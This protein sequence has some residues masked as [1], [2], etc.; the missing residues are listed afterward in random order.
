M[1]WLLNQGTISVGRDLVVHNDSMW[2]DWMTSGM[3]AI[4]ESYI[5][6]QWDTGKASSSVDQIVA[7]LLSLPAAARR[8]IFHSWEARV[9]SLLARLLQYPSSCCGSL[10]GRIHEQADVG[11]ELFAEYMDPSLHAS[12]G[13]WDTETTSLD[14]AQKNKFKLIAS[15]LG[16][17]VGG[18]NLRT[19][20]WF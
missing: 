9:V 5:T 12:F 8:Q 13:I 20:I 1:T 17:E 4:G 18:L 3:L 16:L 7:A 10:V 15:K 11:P 14:E 2:L 6:R 19:M